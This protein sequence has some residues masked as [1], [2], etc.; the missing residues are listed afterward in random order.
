MADQMNYDAAH[1]HV[2]AELETRTEKQLR[3][4]LGLRSGEIKVIVGKK[5]RRIGQFKC[6]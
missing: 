6:L 3:S 4:L 1:K 2:A 5:K